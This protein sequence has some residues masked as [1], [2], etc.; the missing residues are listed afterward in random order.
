[1]D[2]DIVERLRDQRAK[3]NRLTEDLQSEIRRLRAARAAM[4]QEDLAEHADTF[5]DAARPDVRLESLAEAMEEHWH[6][7]IVEV[8]RAVTLPSLYVVLVATDDGDEFEKFQSLDEAKAFVAWM[9]S[10]PED[11]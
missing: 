10:P 5:W 8:G 4:L 6:G 7:Q 1:M 11:A 3:W 9:K 2:V